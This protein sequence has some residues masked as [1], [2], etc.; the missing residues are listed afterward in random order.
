MVEALSAANRELSDE[1][2]GEKLQPHGSTTSSSVNIPSSS[3]LS[4]ANKTVGYSD[5]VTYVDCDYTDLLTTNSDSSDTLLGKLAQSSLN[6]SIT[7]NYQQ[8]P[9]A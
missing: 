6:H 5:H 7:L 9:A 8:H 4:R 2:A 3:S 1:H